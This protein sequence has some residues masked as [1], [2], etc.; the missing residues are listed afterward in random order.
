MANFA[1]AFLKV[2]ARDVYKLHTQRCEVRSA[3]FL[4]FSIYR[5]RAGLN[6]WNLLGCTH[7]NRLLADREVCW[8]EIAYC[9]F[10]S[11]STFVDV[12]CDVA[13]LEKLNN[14]L[15]VLSETK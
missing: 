6:T 12:R 5:T 2:S 9:P 8:L 1:R 15:R 13:K 3:P 4:L 7:Q 14:V 11:K 10:K